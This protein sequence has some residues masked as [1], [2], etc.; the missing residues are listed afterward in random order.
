MLGERALSELAMPRRQAGRATAA[1]FGCELA[2]AGVVV[3]SGLAR[4]I[5]AAAH[6]D[7][8]SCLTA[9]PAAV[10]G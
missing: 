9:T 3:L 10:V 4:G 5:D 8:L 1:R 6:R 7:A 2:E